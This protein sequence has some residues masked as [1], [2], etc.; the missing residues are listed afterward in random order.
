MLAVFAPS[1]SA[2]NADPFPR[3]PALDPAVAFWTGVFGRQSEHTSVIHVASSPGVVLARLDFSPSLPNNVRRE[4]ERA[5]IAQVSAQLRALHKSLVNK[6]ALDAK[7]K[8][9][10][11]RFGPSAPPDQVLKAADDLRSQRGVR[12]RTGRAMEISGHFL[13]MMEA[14]FSRYQLPISLTRLPFVESSFDI[15]AYSKV[16]AAGLWQ[17][18]PATARHYMRLDEAID[19]RRDPWIATDGAARHLSDD[20]ALLQD[21][22][23]AVTAY[24][25]GRNGIRRGLAETGG[26]TLID[27]IDRY[28]NRRFGFASRN[29]YAEFLAVKDIENDAKKFFP[30]LNRAAPIPFVE[31]TLTHYVPYTDLVKAGGGD[32]KLF[33]Q[34]NP[35]Y[36]P[37]VR[38]GRLWV[39][40][41][42]TIRIPTDQA[43]KFNVGYAAL[44]ASARNTSQRVYWR[45]HKVT[46]GAVLGQIARQYGV[47]S[48]AIQRANNL[49]NPNHLR[50]GQVLRIP[51]AD[52]SSPPAT[53]VAAAAPRIHVVQ[54]GQTLSGIARLHGVSIQGLADT[55]QLSNRNAL[56]PGQKLKIP[57]G[58]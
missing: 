43:Q 56:R 20:Y 30:D 51:P 2:N 48:T 41:G 10:Y 9:L 33:Q 8:A 42:S 38:S 26:T 14:T 15:E 6:Q 44:P 50:I 29:F 58:A 36:S 21:W 31:V 24:N 11:A 3:Y 28:E 17:F 46:K 47:S 45:E 55:N 37:E 4:Q 52:G 53:V 34:L 18:M 35:G 32:A 5:A 49:S 23:L 13:P 12:E 7:S 54:S 19:D 25:H 39:P 57:Q 22:P 27:L 1:V 16:G 40:R